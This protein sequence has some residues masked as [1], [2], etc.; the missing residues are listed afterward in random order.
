MTNFLPENFRYD[1]Y[2]FHCGRLLVFL[3]LFN[4]SFYIAR[5]Y[6]SAKKWKETLALYQRALDNCKKALAGWKQQ[7]ETPKLKVKS[8]YVLVR[9]VDQN[10]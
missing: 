2:K 8:E 10:I 1:G 3:L 6:S 5:S 4:R 7:Q 9:V